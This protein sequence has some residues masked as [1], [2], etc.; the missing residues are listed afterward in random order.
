[1]NPDS[2]A[3]MH[4][5]FINV[6][7][8][9]VVLWPGVS[10][11]MNTD[12]GKALLGTPNGFGTAWLLLN[13]YRQLGKRWPRVTIWTAQHMIE[14]F[15]TRMPIDGNYMLWELVDPRRMAC[16]KLGMERRSNEFGSG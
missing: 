7:G 16:V 5:I 2:V 3:I 15:G 4:E 14:V 8:N 11:E 1:M 13:R 10:F 6:R 12:E 9:S